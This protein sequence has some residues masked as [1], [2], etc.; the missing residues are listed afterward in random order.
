ML[1][2]FLITVAVTFVLAATPV[3]ADVKYFNPSASSADW[4]AAFWDSDCSGV[5]TQTGDWD[6]EDNDCDEAVIC[7]DKTANINN[8]DDLDA[9]AVS[10]QSTGIVNIYTGGI[11]NLVGESGVSEIDGAINLEGELHVD[12]LGSDNGIHEHTFSGEG[13]I[14]GTASSA[15]IKV[16][17]TGNT[18]PNKL[19]L[20]ATLRGQ[21]EIVRLVENN[22]A[23]QLVLDGGTVHSD[24]GGL[25][26]IALSGIDDS[27]CS[28]LKVSS[29]TNS[30]LEIDLRCANGLTSCAAVC[31]EYTDTEVLA[32]TL[33]LIDD[34]LTTEN[35]LTMKPGGKIELTTGSA[36]ARFQ[37]PTNACNL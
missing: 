17:G 35:T 14:I 32:G 5:G 30:V 36:I 2:I 27:A 9:Q 13:E 16:E 24:A 21:M 28:L 1:R 15:R 25:L 3:F 22:L 11:L 18:N 31:L 33:R 23:A 19:H 26:R 8:A 34:G 4:D 12:W 6:C 37:A 10:V 29:S 7:D 20:I